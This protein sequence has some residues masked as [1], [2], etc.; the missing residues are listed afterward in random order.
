MAVY[1]RSG[2]KTY[3]FNYYDENGKRRFKST[4]TTDKRAAEDIASKHKTDAALRKHSII[5]TKAEAAQDLLN[6]K[7]APHVKDYEQSMRSRNVTEKHIETSIGMLDRLIDSRGIKTLEDFTGEAVQAFI[8]GLA[9][10]GRANRTIQSHL[11]AIRAFSKWLLKA[12]RIQLDPLVSIEKP[13]SSG[14]TS[15]SRRALTHDEWTL[16]DAYVRSSPTSYGMTGQERALLYATAIQTG[17]RANELRSILRAHMNLTGKQPSILVEAKNTKNRK[18]ARQYIQ[19]ELASE[20]LTL[21]AKKLAGAAVFPM[22]SKFDVADMLR[23][24]ILNARDQWLSTF[25]EPQARIEAEAS[26]FLQVR[27]SLGQVVDFH[28]LRHTTATWLIEAGADP[29]TVQSVLRHSTIKL[30]LDTYGHL[31]PGQE[32]QAVAMIR[33]RFSDPLRA[34]GTETTGTILAPLGRETVPIRAKLCESGE[35]S[36]LAKTIKKPLVSQEKPEVLSN[37]SAGTRTQDQRIKSPLLYRLSYTLP[38]FL[39]PHGFSGHLAAFSA[40]RLR[41]PQDNHSRRPTISI[42]TGN[43]S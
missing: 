40:A 21:T 9:N 14:E 41:P 37:E 6:T 25:K 20:L 33:H 19:P 43:L 16:L 10:A 8:D 3:Y 27:N 26:D 34:T 29:K 17:L 24:D 12:K 2:G 7:I 22:P 39:L 4:G 1:K 30:T 42:S 11:Q 36:Q 5:D 32:A 38:F 31:F 35:S 23:K 18:T 13:K 15:L 28:C